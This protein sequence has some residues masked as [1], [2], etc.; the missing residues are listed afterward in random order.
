MLSTVDGQ[1]E[2][3]SG[4]DDLILSLIF[5]S[6]PTHSTIV[7]SLPSV[8]LPRILG[9]FLKTIPASDGQGSSWSCNNA[10][11]LGILKEFP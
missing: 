10:L 1:S 9:G 6:F 7:F 8:S 5:S 4:D 11:K 2:I 3:M